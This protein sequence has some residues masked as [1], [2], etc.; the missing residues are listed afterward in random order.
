MASVGGH[1]VRH[2]PR[3]PQDHDG[4]LRLHGQAMA[5][6]LLPQHRVSGPLWAGFA[7]AC[8]GAGL[9]VHAVQGDVLLQSRPQRQLHD[10]RPDPVQ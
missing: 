5:D 2:R 4:L 8:R 6:Q 9:A 10:W 3:R 7:Y 1:L